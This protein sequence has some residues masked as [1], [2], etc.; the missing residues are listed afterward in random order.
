MQKFLQRN[1]QA[2]LA[3]RRAGQGLVR[4][5]NGWR[6]NDPATD[7]RDLINFRTINAMATR[8]LIVLA[9]DGQ[10]ARLAKGVPA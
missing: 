4:E 3:M 6:S 1:P 5:R 7:P 2:R 10:S 8:G 9:Q